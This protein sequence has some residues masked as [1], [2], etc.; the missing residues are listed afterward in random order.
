MLAGLSTPRDFKREAV[1][2][3][4]N[5]LFFPEE[6]LLCVVRNDADEFSSAV[7]AAALA[8]LAVR[9]FLFR[10]DRLRPV[11]E[12]A[13]GRDRFRDFLYRCTI[14]PPGRISGDDLR[15]VLGGCSDDAIAVALCDRF[16][17]LLSADGTIPV[18][19]PVDGHAWLLPFAFETR[20][21]PS[22]SPTVTDAVG[23]RIDAW[24]DAMSDLPRPVGCDIRV[25]IVLSVGLSDLPTGSSLLLPVLAAWWRREGLV[26]QYDPFRL[27]FTGSFRSGRL[28]RVETDEKD[29][30]VSAVKDGILFHPSLANR[31]RT[32][33]SLPEGS[34]CDDVFEAVR[35]LAEE[36]TASSLP[37]A[38][39]RILDFE[40]EVRQNRASDWSS[41]LLRLENVCAGLNR[42][43]APSDWLFGLLLRASANCHAGN[44]AEAARLNAEAVAFGRG[45]PRFEPQL[46]RALVEQLVILQDTEDF[47][48]LFSIAPG[49]GERIDS[50][51]R[52]NGESTTAR[53]LRMRFHGSMGQFHAYAALAGVRPDECTP[54]SAKRHFDAAF[55][56]AQ[57]LCEEAAEDELASRSADVA[58]DANYLVLWH[59]LF[60]AA[61]LP[62]A[63]G[64]AL[65][66]TTALEGRARRT[67]LLYAHR[68]AAL[69]L[70]RCVLRGEPVPDLPDA[71]FR[72]V[73]AAPDEGGW[74]AGTT[75]KYL[76]A[77]VA[78]AGDEAE[79]ARLF[80]IAS[81]SIDAGAKGILA[82][83][84]MTIHAEAYRSLRR[85]PA[86]A[87]VAETHRREALRF[88]RSNDPAAL[89]KAPWRAW[90][91]DP[92]SSP[93]PGLSYWY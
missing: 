11:L 25:G 52:G 46:L 28:R 47:E 41:V 66:C 36:R 73:L 54:D 19:N 83:I 3:P 22:G 40:P 57:S 44:T 10:D 30:M 18:F 39:R 49:L 59:A 70:Y 6:T 9:F 77:V 87:A 17:T 67:N 69:G 5:A 63:F 74:I 80:G 84:R 21:D 1:S 16:S 43:Q 62:G 32:R 29:R 88:F 35:D 93:F 13:I 50:Y 42:H 48:K 15:R 81:S 92:E 72:G 53:D 7:R 51:A 23:N 82:V 78:A 27:V 61:G 90:L 64:T 79:A 56:A 2:R 71:D 60:D 76:G 68:D 34:S 55:E 86:L 4:E 91:A 26:P 75:A 65:V 14:A 33:T 58:R 85:F 12:G 31:P 8:E 24:S 38:K 45:R 20:T 37:Y 89:T